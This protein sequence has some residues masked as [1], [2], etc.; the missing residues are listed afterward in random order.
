MH[1]LPLYLSMCMELLGHEY[2]YTETL[3]Y[4]DVRCVSAFE[5]TYPTS[6]LSCSAAPSCGI[7]LILSVE[8]NTKQIE[9]SL[10]DVAL[11]MPSQWAG[12][13]EEMTWLSS[14]SIWPAVQPRRRETRRVV[15]RRQKNG[16]RLWRDG[17]VEKIY[18]SNQML[19]EFMLEPR[20]LLHG[21]WKRGMILSISCL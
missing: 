17:N 5:L 14:S 1:I 21:H 16:T 11:P 4:W 12:L 6:S 13:G 15:L 9:M 19:L 18:R 3:Q 8:Q 2:I 20:C 10:N 7:V